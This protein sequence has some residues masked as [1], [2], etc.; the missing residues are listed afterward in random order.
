MQHD[1]VEASPEQVAQ[2]YKIQ[3]DYYLADPQA[4]EVPLAAYGDLI[5]KPD[6]FIA[7]DGRL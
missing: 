1:Y 6:P 5:P 4:V 7:S 2:A 3:F